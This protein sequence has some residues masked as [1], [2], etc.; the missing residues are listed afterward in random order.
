VL[1]TP[2]DAQHRLLLKTLLVA[3]TNGQPAWRDVRNG[4]DGGRLGHHVPEAGD[5]HRGAQLDPWVCTATSAMRAQ[6]SCQSAGES[7]SQ[8]RS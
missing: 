5:E 3:R 8:T 2:I 4:G 7:A 6:M 1:T